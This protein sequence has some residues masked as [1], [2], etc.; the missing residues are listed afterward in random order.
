MA[1]VPTQIN[2]VRVKFSVTANNSVERKIVQALRLCIKPNIATGYKLKEIYISS[3]NDSH[4]YPNKW[5]ENGF[6]L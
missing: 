2:G 1:K 3:A 4:S 5:N 6:I